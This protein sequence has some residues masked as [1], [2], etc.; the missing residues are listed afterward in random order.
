RGSARVQKAFFV[1]GQ[2]PEP[3]QVIDLSFVLIFR[4]HWSVNQWIPVPTAWPRGLRAGIELSPRLRGV[5]LP[6]RPRA[7]PRLLCNVFGKDALAELLPRFA[8]LILGD[9][10]FSQ[11]HLERVACP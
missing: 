2:Q 7:S 11:L 10:H 8:K 9:G 5:P 6:P 4:S 3:A 1:L